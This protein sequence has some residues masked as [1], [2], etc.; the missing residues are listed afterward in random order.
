MQKYQYKPLSDPEAEIRVA[1][2]Q[3]GVYI[4]EL[5]VSFRIRRLLI[6]KTSQ[7]S[8]GPR[9]PPLMKVS[10]PMS[11]RT[12][13]DYE[14][15]SYAWGSVDDPSS[16]LVKKMGLDRGIIPISRNLDIALRHL[17][18][19]SRSRT[20]WIDAICIDQDGTEEKSKQVAMM[21]RIFSLASC[22]TIWLGPEEDDSTKALDL[23]HEIA[24]HIDFNWHTHELRPSQFTNQPHWANY[25]IDYPFESGELDPVSALLQRPYFERTWVRQEVAL[26]TQASV[27]CGQQRLPWEEFRNIIAC[28]NWKPI[29]SQA[30]VE[31]P[32]AEFRRVTEIAF[33]LCDIEVSGLALRSIR[34]DLRN[35][36]CGDPRDQLYSIL[37]LLHDDDK[38]LNIQPNYIRTVEDL[39]THVTRLKLATHHTLELLESCDISSRELEIPS[40][41]PD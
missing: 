19:Q 36:K 1:V 22:V 13:F 17:R 5:C 3:P 18:D 31:Q 38:Q 6:G 8:V 40:W 35:I 14:A 10:S 7:I 24:Q 39:Y 9:K 16:L 26:A 41:V 34:F 33:G 20:I 29:L 11:K 28:L 30:L 2:L 23:M 21:G 4:D 27:Q 25:R 32:W 37:S 15:L 12:S